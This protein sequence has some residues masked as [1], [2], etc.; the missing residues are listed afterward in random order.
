MKH[1][2]RCDTSKPTAAFGRSAQRADGLHP[3]CKACRADVQRSYRATADGR[4][5]DK[6]YARSAKGKTTRRR[7]RATYR[8]T[9]HGS[10]VLVAARR[11]RWDLKERED[12]RRHRQTERG[13]AS[14]RAAKRRYHATPRGRASR[15]EIR[16]RYQR[17]AYRRDPSRILARQAV[18]HALRAGRLI[19]PERCERCG[20]RC[21]PDAH[22]H[23]GYA[24]Q[25]RLDVQWLCPS[26][27]HRVVH[28]HRCSA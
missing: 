26:Q 11:R 23:K 14:Q 18:R 16:A 27:C 20:Q 4:A 3:W 22:H 21:R 17:E 19:R 12:Q 10:A 2:S 7:A 15:R 6:R 28:P 25:H 8:M 9:P 5:R 24:K 13:R 1:C